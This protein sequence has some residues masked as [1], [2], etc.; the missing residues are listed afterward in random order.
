VAIVEDTGPAAI[1]ALAQ[2]ADRVP[3]LAGQRVDRL[4]PPARR[5]ISRIDAQLVLGIVGGATHAVELALE[6]RQA[7]RD[8][9]PVVIHATPLAHAP[10][11]TASALQVRW[12]CLA[13]AVKRGSR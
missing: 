13:L 11:V 4:E 7:P 5:G 9:R 1:V 12:L 8:H 6:E 10:R 2:L 3:G